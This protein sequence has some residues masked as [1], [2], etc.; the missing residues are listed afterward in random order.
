[1]LSRL[2]ASALPFIPKSIVHRVARRYVAGESLEEALATIARLNQEGSPATLSLLGE[3]VV[4][5]QEVEATVQEYL[6]MLDAIRERDLPSGISV[7]PTHLGLR[8]DTRLCFE[9]L[10]RLL[11]AAATSQTF[12]RLDMEDRT[13]TDATLEIHKALRGEYDNVGVALQACLRR[14]LD[15]LDRLPQEANIRL[16]KGIYLEP[17]DVS[18]HDAHEIRENFVRAME[19]LMQRP[20]YV[21]IAT[22]DEVLIGRTRDLVRRLGLTAE[23]YELQMLLGVRGRLRRSLVAQGYGVR[24]YVPYGPD[25]YRYSLRRLRESPHILTPI[26]RTLLSPDP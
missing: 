23:R 25:W 24:V 6:R 1:M 18:Y 9:S 14:T 10:R 26:L 3:E 5:T 21:G 7:K 17:V 20:G 8:I 22:H 19:V 11:A 15:D 12:V 16:C 2:V 13:T 4:E